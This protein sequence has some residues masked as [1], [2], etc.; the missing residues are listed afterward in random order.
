[1]V[2]AVFIV[3]TLSV[4]KK[5]AFCFGQNFIKFPPILLTFGPW[6]CLLHKHCYINIFHLNNNISNHIK[7]WQLGNTMILFKLCM[8]LQLLITCL[9]ETAGEA[10]F[11]MSLVFCFVIN[12]LWKQ[13]PLSSGNCQNTANLL[14]TGGGV[15]FLRFWTFFGVRKSEFPCSGCLEETLIFKIMID[16]VTLWSKL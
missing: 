2:A 15:V 9:S 3:H 1:M 14:I 13:L 10:L 11:L 5:T 4:S 6:K 7:V 16:D 12:V 8:Q